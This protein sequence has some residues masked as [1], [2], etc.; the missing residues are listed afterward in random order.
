MAKITIIGAG[1]RGFAGQCRIELRDVPQP[2]P[3]QGEVLLRVRTSAL[4]GSEL[5]MYRDEN[6]CL[7]ACR[8]L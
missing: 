4:C 6:L 8:C 2:E 7:G 5:E 1:S 3:H